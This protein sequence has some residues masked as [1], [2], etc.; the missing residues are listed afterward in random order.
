MEY[1]HNYLD[2]PYNIFEPE[3]LILDSIHYLH[4]CARFNSIYDL[5][6][7]LNSNPRLNRI[8]FETLH[9][10]E[11]NSNFAGENYADALKNLI[12]LPKKEYDYFL[13]ISKDLDEHQL[14]DMQDYV[15][16]KSPGGGYLN[17]PSYAAGDPLCYRTVTNV[18]KPKFIRINI[19]LGYSYVTTK[20]Q[21]LNRA[22][23][24]I[25]LVNS[26]EN[27]GYIVDINAFDMSL[28]AY[29]LIDINVNLKN[30]NE[31]INK[32]SLYKALCNVEFLRRIIFRVYESLDVQSLGWQNS[33]GR[34]CSSDLIRKVKKLTKDDILIESPN[35][36]GIDRGNTFF[37]DLYHVLQKTGLSDVIDR[38]SVNALSRILEK[39]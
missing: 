35:A 5:Y 2:Y 32:V 31:T 27:L 23:I 16:T 33:Y 14:S 20:S 36:M 3:E 7:Y 11:N 6:L 9:S 18:S 28:M 30:S 25:A 8:V 19:D 29:E 15:S 13:K 22:L 4:Y 37:E 17:I 1:P 34:V 21:V 38:N 39:K 26:L 12:E 24:V 10:L